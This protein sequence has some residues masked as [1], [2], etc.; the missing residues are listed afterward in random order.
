MTRTTL[1]AG[2]IILIQVL[3]A[4][5]YAQSEPELRGQCIKDG[6]DLLERIGNPFSYNAHYSKKLHGCFKARAF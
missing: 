2:L 3:C 6:R 4:A 1:A 5:A